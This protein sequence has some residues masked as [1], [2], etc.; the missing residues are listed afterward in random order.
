MGKVAEV[1]IEYKIHWNLIQT[2]FAK[3]DT[4]IQT[5]LSEENG[6]RIK[7]N[8]TAEIRCSSAWSHFNDIFCTIFY[9]SLSV[10]NADAHT[11]YIIMSTNCSLEFVCKCSCVF[12]MW[13]WVNEPPLLMDTI[14]IETMSW[15]I[16]QL[17]SG[18]CAD[19]EC[20]S[21]NETTMDFTYG[22]FSPSIR[23]GLLWHTLTTNHQTTDD[24]EFS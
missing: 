1:H 8:K 21:Q 24:V 12:S 7:E 22:F 3:N 6:S 20:A 18:D 16:S 19:F 5:V 13:I 14:K 23:L 9:C 11:C 17:L 15:I 2:M 4:L 10:D